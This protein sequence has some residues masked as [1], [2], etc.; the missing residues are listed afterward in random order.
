MEIRDSAGE[1]GPAPPLNQVA[2]SVVDLRRTEHGF[3]EGPG[4]LPAG[5]HRW[6]VRSFLAGR[7]QGLP[8][9]ASTCWWLVG[10]DA[11][12]Q[13]EFFQFERP[14]AR[15]RPLDRHPTDIG[16]SRMGFWSVCSNRMASKP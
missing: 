9:A 15:P 12:F 2:M 7:I 10:R 11:W 4:F 8:S 14:M 1:G 6:Q 5:S 3:R 16:C 13:L